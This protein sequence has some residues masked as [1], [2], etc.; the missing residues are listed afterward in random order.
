M[1]ESHLEG[2]NKRVIR[3]RWREQAG[4]RNNK[5]DGEI[6]RIKSEEGQERLL[7]NKWKSDTDKV[8]EVLGI[9]RKRQT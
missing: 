5:E 1:L 8:E 3:G 2:E 6:F 7:E 9:S 4:N